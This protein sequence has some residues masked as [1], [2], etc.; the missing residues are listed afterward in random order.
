MNVANVSS[1][2]SSSGDGRDLRGT[3]VTNSELLVM[4]C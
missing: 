1:S 4:G 3:Q 2:S